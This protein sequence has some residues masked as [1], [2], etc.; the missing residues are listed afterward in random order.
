MSR[1]ALV[2]VTVAA[3]PACGGGG[4]DG[5]TLPTSETCTLAP[6]APAPTVTAVEIGRVGPGDQFL[7]ITDDSVVPLVVG[8][9]G[10]DMIVATLR[11][12]GSDVGGCVAQSTVLEQLDGTEISGEASA[13]VTHAAGAGVWQTGDLL[14]LYYSWP[15]QKVRI[16]TTVAGASAAVELWTEYVGEVDAPVA[17]ARPDG[18]LPDGGLPDALATDALPDT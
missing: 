1:L 3:V 6:G 7:P 18:A 5:P 11:L 10:S 4:C 13:L 14:L 16:R 15:G 8:G 17:D 9:Q 2:L 12:R